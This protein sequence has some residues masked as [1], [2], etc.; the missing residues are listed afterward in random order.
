MK[1]KEYCI[2]LPH[3]LS[4]PLLW[5]GDIAITFP[6]LLAAA[7][8]TATYISAIPGP[9]FFKLGPN[10]LLSSCAAGNAKFPRSRSYS[11]LYLEISTF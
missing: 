5:E 11:V 2:C 7:A 8:A 4:P 9:I 1:K 10:D 3:F 6:A